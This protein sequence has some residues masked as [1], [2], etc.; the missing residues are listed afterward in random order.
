MAKSSQ[1]RKSVACTTATID[2]PPSGC[3]DNDASSLA[4]EIASGAHCLRGADSGILRLRELEV[5]Y[6]V[7]ADRETRFVTRGRPF[8]EGQPSTIRTGSSGS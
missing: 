2:G 5:S 6:S 7:A 8:G 3:P 1:L 4:R